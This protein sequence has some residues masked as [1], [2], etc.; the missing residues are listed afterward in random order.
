M[1]HS[2]V[3]VE[4]TGV[5]TG[6]GAVQRTVPVTLIKATAELRSFTIA[7]VAF[8]RTGLPLAKSSL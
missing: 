5:D 8:T 4:R 6:K 2:M 3:V 7:M 1:S